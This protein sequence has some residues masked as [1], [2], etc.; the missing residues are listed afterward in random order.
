[1][2]KQNPRGGRTLARSLLERACA[3][4]V[5]RAHHA[6][7]PSHP[8]VSSFERKWLM[9]RRRQLLDSLWH[10]DPGSD[11][12]CCRREAAINRFSPLTSSIWRPK[13]GLEVLYVSSEVRVA[14]GHLPCVH[15]TR[16]STS[17]ST[18]LASRASRKRK[19][20]N[21]SLPGLGRPSK[22]DAILK[23]GPGGRAS[24]FVTAGFMVHPVQLSQTA[25]CRQSTCAALFQRYSTWR[26]P[27]SCLF[28]KVVIWRDMAVD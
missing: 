9:G 15:S 18:S 4:S 25:H 2:A 14:T 1:M 17:H 19:C 22:A 8:I 23:Q 3:G 28:D 7:A 10:G 11:S 12:E 5:N 27:C 13:G 24:R 16:I 26:N 20:L 21:W 6:Q